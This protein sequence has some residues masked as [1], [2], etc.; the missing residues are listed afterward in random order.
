[1]LCGF[2]P[3]IDWL[4]AFRALQGI[5]GA[6][7]LTISLPIVLGA[8]PRRQQPGADA[9]RLRTALHDDAAQQLCTVWELEEAAVKPCVHFSKNY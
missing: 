9:S 1:M 5:G 8:F 6:A 3:T 4:I 2:A 7:L